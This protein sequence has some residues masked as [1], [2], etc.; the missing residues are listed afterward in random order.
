M[1]PKYLVH[2]ENYLYLT[3]LGADASFCIGTTAFV[4]IGL[5]MVSYLK[6][7]CGMLKIAR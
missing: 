6:H 1:V 5:M 7:T 3:L 2:Q 4:A